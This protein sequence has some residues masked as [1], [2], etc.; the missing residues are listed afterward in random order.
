[1]KDRLVLSFFLL[2]FILKGKATDDTTRVLFI[3]NS[4]TYYN[5]M[6]FVFKDMANIKGRKVAVTMYAPGGT[7]FVN[8]YTDPNV[9][10]LF[11]AGNWDVIVL[12]PGS[13]E[14]AGASFPV[15]TTIIRG[16]VLLDS[17]Y[18]YNSCARVYLYEIPYGVPSA[19]TYSTYFTVQA[20]IR[21]SVTKMADSLK[22]QMIPAGECFKRYY[23]L[24]Q[25]LLL[26][27]A[28][29][30]IHPNA[31]G[32]YLVASAA[33]VSIFQ[34]TISGCTHYA[35]LPQDTAKKFFSIADTCVLNHKA[36]WRINTYNVNATFTHTLLGSN[37]VAFT[38]LPSNYTSISWNFGDNTSSSQLTPVHQYAQPGTYT[39]TLKAF[40]NK[41]CADSLLQ[42]INTTPLSLNALSV[43]DGELTVYPNPASSKV[44][45]SGSGVDGSDYELY[46]ATGSKVLTG[47]LKLT[48]AIDISA[49]PTGIYFLKLVPEQKYENKT[50]PLIRFCKSEY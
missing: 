19:T 30:D 14:S 50:L 46:S 23:G 20:R 16:K 29:N 35:G 3:G 7:G 34:D 41:G 15:S 49:L 9:F 39:V 1:M 6:P 5:N 22:L 21:D 47:N 27:G 33:Y 12:Q 43:S 4:I 26:H 17:I 42:I 45:V 25:N 13:G 11:K 44:N 10:S 18:F 40:D 2:L 8:H 28:Y 24:H 48:G 31:N 38:A 37:S 36:W 32:S